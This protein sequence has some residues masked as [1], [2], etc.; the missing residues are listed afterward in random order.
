MTLADGLQEPTTQEKILDAAER[1][2]ADNG[3]AG[4]SVR[5]ITAEAGVNLASAHYHF[6]SKEALIR[7]VLSRRVEP[8]TQERLH[9][10]EACLQEAGD[11]LP[12]LEGI[13]EAFIGPAVRL[14][15][16]PQRAVFMRLMGRVH[17]EAGEFM[18]QLINELFS[19]TARRFHQA[20][21]AALPAFSEEDL[22]WKLNFMVGAMAFTLAT[23]QAIEQ[24]SGGRCDPA[25]S[26]GVLAH[27]TA[28]VAAGLRAEVSGRGAETQRRGKR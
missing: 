27:M 1:L 6:G 3:F 17:S 5:A 20:L 19:D 24:V 25:D 9:L 10:L 18:P 4:T 26:E 8:I 12:R 21:K 7:M 16:D 11:G 15:R 23:P 2:F 28:F 14:S 13:A 22:F